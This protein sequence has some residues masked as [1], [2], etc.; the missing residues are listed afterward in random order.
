M[1]TV[2]MVKIIFLNGGYSINHMSTVYIQ[3][4][5]YML[6]LKKDFCNITLYFAGIHQL[7]KIISSDQLPTERI[8]VCRACPVVRKQTC[9]SI[10]RM[11]GKNLEV[12]KKP[13]KASGMDT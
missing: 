10:L 8:A 2:V 13:V 1:L 5:T 3:K 9:V 12:R 11:L 4:K 7:S 6:L